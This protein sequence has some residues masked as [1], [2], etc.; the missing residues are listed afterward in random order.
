[1]IALMGLA[2]L[3]FVTMALLL[4]QSIDPVAVLFE[5][6]SALGTV[7]LSIGATGKLDGIGKIIIMAAM[8]I[9][10]VGP[11]SMFAFLASRS[12]VT[13]WRFP[14]EEIDVG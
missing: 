12:H 7:G 6:V 11:V 5:A 3:F 2:S 10:R 4:T 1:M 13:D 9:G 14:R 8:F